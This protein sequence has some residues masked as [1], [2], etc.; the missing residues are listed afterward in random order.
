M[1]EIKN[2]VIT[3]TEES[4]LQ[5]VQEES[6]PTD[7]QEGENIQGPPQQEEEKSFSQE[8]V[9]QIVKERLAREREKQAAEMEELR[10]GI[11]R[12]Q[13]ENYL[14]ENKYPKKL[15]EVIEHNTV[16]ELE[17]KIWSLAEVLG[18]WIMP[19]FDGSY[20]YPLLLE[21]AIYHLKKRGEREEK[22]TSIGV[23]D[24]VGAIFKKR[25]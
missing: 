13:A 18:D 1:E 24:A 6:K 4:D 21:E 15:A 11:L 5:D 8:Q 14:L 20:K 3:G 12:Q 23:D 9:N 22:N 16:E 7:S 19:D 25:I 2:T 17:E 10:K